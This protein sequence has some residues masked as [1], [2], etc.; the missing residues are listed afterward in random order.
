MNILLATQNQHKISEIQ[1]ILP[2][3]NFTIPNTTLNI[4]EGHNSYIANALLKAKT[5]TKHYPDHYILA[6]DSGLE[7]M[8][9]NNAPGVITAE[10]AGIHASQAEHNNKLLSALH[11]I[12]FEQRDAKFVAY[13][14]LLTPTKNIFC[15][16]GEV[17]GKIATDYSGNQGFGYDPLF[18]PLEYHYQLTMADLSIQQKNQISHRYRAL[19][20]IKD[21]LHYIKDAHE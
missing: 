16:R 11:H 9:L 4:I 19:L 20:G 17:L 6:D 5:W 1:N 2:H 13:I 14:V 18:L 21:Y 3:I 10:W 7:V 12:P 8:A 15:S